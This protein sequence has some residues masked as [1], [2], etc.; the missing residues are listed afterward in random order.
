MFDAGCAGASKSIHT[1]TG[2]IGISFEDKKISKLLKSPHYLGRNYNNKCDSTKYLK[3]NKISKA[4]DYLRYYDGTSIIDKIK[5]TAA[6]IEGVVLDCHYL[7]GGAAFTEEAYILDLQYS[8][9]SC[10]Y[11][12][13]I[14]YDKPC[15]SVDCC[16]NSTPCSKPDDYVV[17]PL[18]EYTK[19]P[20]KFKRLHI[21][22]C[23]LHRN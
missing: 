9:D 15:R 22:P 21:T 19:R 3:N 14:D 1:P 13:N 5:E 23:S 2:N 10:P 7:D 17:I 12:D 16:E 8:Q 20:R 4:I 18:A 6:K 11:C